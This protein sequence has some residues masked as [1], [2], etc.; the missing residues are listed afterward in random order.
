MSDSTGGRGTSPLQ[1]FQHITL[2]LWAVHVKNQ[3]QMVLVPPP[4]SSGH[5]TALGYMLFEGKYQQKIPILD[6]ISLY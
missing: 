6:H 1:T 5:G 2:C 4:Q 3:L